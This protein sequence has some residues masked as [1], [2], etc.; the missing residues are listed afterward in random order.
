M[1][2]PGIKRLVLSPIRHFIHHSVLITQCYLHGCHYSFNHVVSNRTSKPRLYIALHVIAGLL[3]AVQAE[4]HLHLILASC[5]LNQ[6]DIRRPSVET[7]MQHPKTL[8]ICAWFAL[9][10]LSPLTSPVSASK[11]VKTVREKA[12]DTTAAESPPGVT[13]EG[14]IIG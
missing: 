5:V 12:N 6:W 9:L 11:S 13:L 4:P 8:N 7:I 1:R 14:V 10:A 2:P 3:Q